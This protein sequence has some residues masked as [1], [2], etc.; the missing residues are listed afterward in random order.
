MKRHSLSSPLP[1][2]SIQGLL[3]KN[4]R[5]QVSIQGLDVKSGCP[6]DLLGRSAPLLVTGPPSPDA[7]AQ[8][9]L[10]LVAYAK[11]RAS[12]SGVSKA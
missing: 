12:A 4:K 9:F 5:L 6:E 1:P 7:A 11:F 3:H 10:A 2:L 8:G